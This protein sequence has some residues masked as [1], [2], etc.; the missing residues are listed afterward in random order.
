MRKTT[1]LFLVDTKYQKQLKRL[2]FL[3]VLLFALFFCIKAFSA[4]I[5]N[6]TLS[7]LE[8]PPIQVTV[9]C[10]TDL[11]VPLT[12][13]DYSDLSVSSNTS[14][15][16]V[17][18]C[19]IQ[20]ENNLTDANESNF[21]SVTTLIGL[22]VT[23]T[24]R[25][26]DETADDFYIAGSYA[27]FLIENSSVLQADLLNAIVVRTYLDGVEQEVS[28]GSSLAVLDSDLLGAD[29][30]HVGFYTTLD[31]DAIE[32]SISSL[33][34]V[35]ST[36]NIYHAVSNSFCAGPVLEDNTPTQLNKSTFPARIVSEHT[37]TSGITVGSVSNVMNAVDSNT[38]NYAS[39]DLTASVIGS[40]SIAIKDELTDYPSGTYVAFDVEN[41]SVLDVELLNYFTVTT[42][43]N[44]V[45]QESKTGSAELL[46]VD[47][48]L[49]VTGTER[50][51]VGFVATMPFDEARLTI[52]QTLSLDLGSTRV[53]GLIIEAFAEGD[54]E[55]DMP[56]VLNNPEHSVI[57]NNGHTGIDGVA[58]VGCSIDNATNVI[59][60]NTSDF[61]TINIVAGV[62]GTGSIAVENVLNTYTAGTN[63][64]FII[65]DTNDLLQA[66]LLNT[67]T[68][69]TYLNGTEQ[70]SETGAGLLA[71]EALGL[72]NITP[73][74]TD[75][76]NLVGFTTTLPY[77]EVQLTVGS[78]VAAL[79]S[80][81]VYG[82]YVDKSITIDGTIS[83]ETAA[84]A[85]DGSITTMVSGG[86]PP[87]SY[88]W[89][90]GGQTASS[91][92]GLAAGTYTVTV[93][94]SEGCTSSS[95]FIVYTDGIQYPVPCNT[96]N[97]VAITS[98]GFTDLTVEEDTNGIDA[99]GLNNIIDADATNYA[100][101]STTI[102]LGVTHAITVTDNT[103][104]EFFESGS[105]A[106]FL[107]ENS[108]VIQ[109]DL[110]NA[111]SITTYLDGAQ[112]ETNTSTSLIAIDSPILGTDQ[113]YVGFYSTMDYDAI[114]I[115]IS[116]LVD[117]LSTTRIYHAVTNNFCEGPELV[118]NT[119][120]A[121][122][123]PDFPVRVVDEHT[124]TG[125]LLTLGSVN[126]INR[127]IDS[128]PN[129]YASIDLF[130]GVIG[131]AS[132]AFKDE[133]TDY[134]VN[135]YAG[136]DIE[137]A[138]ILSTDLIDA[139]TI[140]TYLDGVLV[141]SKT[142]GTEL[143]PV[144]SGLLFTGSESMRLGFVASAPFDEVQLSLSQTVSV[145]LGSTRVY[146]MIL[147]SFCPGTID[148][149]VPYVLSNPDN[150][151]II[152]NNHTGTDGVACMACE[153]DNAINVISEDNSDFAL[154][155][156]V[157]NVA[158][159]ASISVQ[160]V[161]MDYPSGTEA[162]FV[163]RDTNDLLEADLLNSLTITTYLDG[164]Q[165]DQETGA[166]LL[167]L[168]A[169]GLVN[170]TPTSTDS[171]YIVSFTTTTSF[172]EIQLT[173][174]SLVGV[175]NSIEVYGSYVDTTNT[176]FCQQADIALI[177]SGVFNDTDG[178]GCTDAG[179]IINYTFTVTNPGNVSIESVV[180]TDPMIA[181][182]FTLAS[183]DT[184]GDSELDTDETWVYNASY[185][186]TQ[187][188]IDT[189]SVTNQ[190]EVTGSST[191]GINVSDLSD[192]NS[193][194]EDDAT[195]TNLC[196][197]ES[198]AIIKQG[199][200]VTAEPSGCTIAGDTVD[201]VFTVTNEGNTTL[202]AV[203][204]TDPM[205]L[206]AI[207]LSSGDTDSDN[208]LDVDET[209]IY[210]ASYTITAADIIAG[211]VTNQATVEA[212][213]VSGGTASDDSDDNSVLEDDA[214]V[215]SLCQDPG[216]AVVKTAVFNDEDADGCA[217]SGETL[218]YTFTVTN[219]G[220][221]AL[222][223]VVLND[224]VLGG[225]IALDSGDINTNSMLDVGEIWIYTA[226]YPLT[227]ND[228]DT[229]SVTNQA[230]VSGESS[231]GV[232]VTDDSD[233]DN[234]LE[235][236]PTTT[237]IC[238]S[239]AIALIKQGVFNDEDTDGCSDVGETI[240]YTF[241]VTNQGNVSVNTIGITDPMLTGLL[242]LPSGDTD[243]DDELDVTETWVYTA[244]YTITQ[245]DI[246]N[247][248][249]SNQATVTGIGADGSNV[250]DLSDDDSVSENDSTET[251]LCQTADIA[252]IK[253][254]IFNDEN[255]NGCSDAGE[256]ITFTFTV[257][258][259][260][261]ISINT[262]GINDPMLAGLIS[263]PSGDTD[264]DSQLDVT[265]TWTFT[266]NYTITQTDIDAGSV[267]NQAEVTGVGVNGINVNDLSH[268]SDILSDGTTDMVLCQS[269]DIALIKTA[270][271]NDENTD[272]CAN[273][274]ET[275]SYSFAVTNQGNVSINTVAIV[276]PLITNPIVLA[277]GDADGDSELDVSETWTFTAN[278]TITQADIDAGSVSNQATV[279][280][281]GADG[282]NVS[283]MSDDD[284]ISQDDSTITP[285]CQDEGI[286][287][288]KTA[289]FNDEDGNGCSDVGETLTYTFTVS[290]QGNT[291]IE[292]LV[293]TDAMLGTSISL[294]SGDV[295]S[296]NELDVNETWVYTGVFTLT[297]IDINVGTLSNQATIEG[298]S[299]A[300]GNNVGD[301][302][303]DNSVLEDDP[304]VTTLCNTSSISLEK[305]GVF[306]DENGSGAV[307]VG[308]TITY[309]FTVYNT[310]QTTLTNITIQDDMLPGI[311][312]QGGPIAQLL[313]GE[314]D[315]STFMATYTVR[316]EDLVNMEVVNQA[317]V[318]A[319]NPMGETI[320]DMSDDP[321][322]FNDVDVDNDGNP[323]DPTVS[324]L[325]AVS[326]GDFEIFNGISPDGDGKNDF[327]LIEGIKNYPNNNLKV[328][329][330]WGVLVYET[331][332]YGIN[333]NVF[334]GISE[335][336]ATIKQ[337]DE[338]PTGTYYYILTR[339]VGQETLVD[340]G[341][342][343]I[344]RN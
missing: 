266:A 53:Y 44:G 258:N 199:T 126:N 222:T 306:N 125:G 254:A 54:L 318:T 194:T 66:D 339:F 179:E 47:S 277:S 122:T 17:L 11:P 260:G 38:N 299:I 189:G 138:S 132:I 212:T 270:V 86:T 220:N 190:A 253:T 249:V 105:Y 59:N 23:H 245:A 293:L 301:I 207:T 320:T 173:V 180:L 130:A 182:P 70:E 319:E 267:S 250:S 34:G 259:Q 168:E 243:G 322:N 41:T 217:N 87:Y 101:V 337:K 121:V 152:N 239:S 46:S 210:T 187:D 273:V 48:G 69:T 91:I 315:N 74:E 166:N 104:G 149:D 99:T 12:D 50:S 291:A 294:D 115:S 65:R 336:R 52:N 264:G 100:V 214:T 16:C 218:T 284:N 51:Q 188:D 14:G 305:V 151:V 198:I 256:T 82:S 56:T 227:Q 169:L 263:L 71:L 295:D 43:L 40:G 76:F 174:A 200:I 274:G 127:A 124:G 282:T 83:N 162:G 231:L 114:E 32:I 9:P 281:V 37:G 110:L 244:D 240:T 172:D 6:I 204:V 312:V 25:V 175:V 95:E 242:S 119:A 116:S 21:T 157:A 75:G 278:Y 67:L 255:T 279:T 57:I 343:Y 183:G 148:C 84:G 3:P 303:D 31:Y 224:P 211:Q 307:Q 117:V 62:A 64:G 341:Y 81:E 73:S 229:G 225:V 333:G 314:S 195:V 160:D 286:A 158:G 193:V 289:V 161:L 236:D 317:I 128:N 107:I 213:T 275:I 19:G 165:Q 96:E 247:G 332:G 140:S 197:T 324:V 184:D 238:Q 237:A 223:N 209:W 4:D 230:S 181:N 30:Y 93:T 265:E 77:D 102:G 150:S 342:L 164:V 141:E 106:G 261:N 49:L 308:E 111:I 177:K 159:T 338:L 112:Q 145:D 147:Q 42:Y 251:T 61:T 285:L 205:I 33:A 178:D 268:S 221:T 326:E 85:S 80:I 146:G 206:G 90:P 10:N 98:V 215:V 248:L 257:T 36:T 292:N 232:V 186:I 191:G 131:T 216:I 135:T 109:A 113:Y 60:E 139:I 325:P 304:T 208:E 154:I 118:C 92:S 203:N 323:D 136:F 309:S 228:I 26:S 329:N 328:Y 176:A 133:I 142:G 20:D 18:G 202:T 153:V 78:L 29:K 316:E 68:V 167:A 288:I 97:P 298:V 24:L 88:L 219:Q 58:C 55:C 108:S 271:F 94:D 331:D 335:G 8:K 170:I 15:L 163:I 241:T 302:S 234:V 252:L 28:S 35:L 272:G 134:Q 156:V 196:Q 120:T 155:N 313:P 344:K 201:F 283:D 310:G 280:G 13:A 327:F 144:D 233:D 72:V 2:I 262:I 171:F 340:K 321:T 334:R 246:D 137:N 39:I 330:R 1:Y 297:D 296:D 45:Q 226:N 269:A 311:V 5:E 129:N 276:D 235:D 192:D 300:T 79:N 123:K 7:P 63:T 290:N 27:G 287:L 103:S 185:T 89:S 22:G 143:L